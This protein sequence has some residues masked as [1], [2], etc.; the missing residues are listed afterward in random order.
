MCTFKI[1]LSQV[2]LISQKRKV[3]MLFSLRISFPKLLDAIRTYKMERKCPTLGAG[4][5]ICQ[6]MLGGSA[7]P[8]GE[9]C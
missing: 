4:W 6:F 1:D 9:S 8:G 2:E 3:I 7:V 5:R